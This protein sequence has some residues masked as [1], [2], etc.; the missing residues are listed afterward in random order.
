MSEETPISPS[1][2]RSASSTAE[3]RVK[4]ES[5]LLFSTDARI[6]RHDVGRVD[7][8]FPDPGALPA[9]D[10]D[11]FVAMMRSDPAQA[12][13][14]VRAAAKA[15]DAQAQMLYAQML[16]EGR[17]VPCDPV[18]GL[19]WHALAAHAGQAF[20]MNMVGRCHELGVGTPANAELAAVWYRKA[21]DGGSMWGMYNYANLLATG[22]GAA[23]DARQAFALYRRA[24][25]QGH[26][27][28]MNLV[29]RHYE[30]GWEVARDARLAAD[31]YRRSAEGGD[32]RG[33][34]SHAAV[35]T[36]QGDVDGAVHWLRR[37]AEAAR[38]DLLRRV[39]HE[40]ADSR[41]AE[42]RGVAK[43]LLVCAARRESED[44]RKFPLPPARNFS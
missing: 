15:G 2:P 5:R 20:A 39:A 24:A 12:L 17:G 41:H 37:A 29:G 18:E 36:Q 32:F 22:R 40:L 26:A 8:S 31:W 38:P 30:E 23:R 1:F 42:L 33:Q 11:A 21:A 43:H 35:L 7:R 27:K 3:G 13:A 4:Q 6:R 44:G 34:I 19:H 9:F 16:C 25:E 14:Q 10:R 28:S